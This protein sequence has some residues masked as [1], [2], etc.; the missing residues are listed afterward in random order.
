MM[1]DRAYV[2]QAVCNPSRQ[3]FL[4]ARRP[5]TTQVWNMKAHVRDLFPNA[6]SLPGAFKNAGFEMCGV[7]KVFHHSEGSSNDWPCAD[8]YDPKKLGA[9]MIAD[10]SDNRYEDGM[11]MDRTLEK[12]SEFALK[13]KLRSCGRW[14]SASR[15]W[16]GFIRSASST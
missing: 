7:G 16:R 8:W 9:A 11:A 4:T 12:L 1:F 3:S 13:G 14:V 6:V 2:Q 5:D 10:L 15:T